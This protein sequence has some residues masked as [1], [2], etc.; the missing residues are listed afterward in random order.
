MIDALYFSVCADTYHTQ[1]KERVI[2]TERE[3]GEGETT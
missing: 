3:R 2:L 1:R